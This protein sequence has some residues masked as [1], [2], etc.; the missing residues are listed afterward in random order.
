MLRDVGLT[1]GYITEVSP[2]YP[3]PAQPVDISIVIKNFT[4]CGPRLTQN[5]LPFLAF[6]L[7]SKCSHNVFS[8][9]SSVCLSHHETSFMFFSSYFGFLV[10]VLHSGR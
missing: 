1:I 5:L 9:S 10:I 8:V 3:E 7:A 6:L 4:V 2:G